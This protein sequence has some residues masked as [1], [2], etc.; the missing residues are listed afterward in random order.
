MQLAQLANLYIANE[1]GNQDTE[2]AVKDIQHAEYGCK[3]GLEVVSFI[4]TDTELA[5]AITGRHDVTFK[6]V[7]AGGVIGCLWGCLTVELVCGCGRRM[8]FRGFLLKDK[9]ADLMSRDQ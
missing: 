9:M 5:G 3:P 8:S 6:G 7:V 4:G 2:Q 1:D